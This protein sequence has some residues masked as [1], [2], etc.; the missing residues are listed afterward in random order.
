MKASDL[1]RGRLSQ[2]TPT[3]TPTTFGSL[4]SPDVPT[5]DKNS[6]VILGFQPASSLATLRQPESLLRTSDFRTSGQSTNEGC[7]LNLPS[8]ST[9]GGDCYIVEP[10]KDSERTREVK[11][12]N[13]DQEDTVTDNDRKRKLKN[14]LEQLPS[15]KKSKAEEERSAQ[16]PSM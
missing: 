6:P 15:T 11:A 7:G 9:S 1:V 10:G 8:A 13:P 5:S 12:S 3:A 14:D 4:A 2:T 16:E